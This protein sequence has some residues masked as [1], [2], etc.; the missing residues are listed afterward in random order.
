MKIWKLA[1]L[2]IGSLITLFLIV[3]A[4]NFFTIQSKQPV[5]D[6]EKINFDEEKAIK[7]LSEAITYKTISYQDRSKFELEEF[8]RFIDFLDR[9]YPSVHRELDLERVN[10]Y[11]LLYTWKG[12]D[13]SKKP[14]G[15]TSHYDVVPVLQGTEENWDHDPFSG[16]VSGDKIWGRG[17]L[18]DK[19]GVIG[20]LQALEHLIDEGFQPERDM[21]FMFGHDEEIGGEEGAM[22]IAALLKER[23]VQFDFVLDE[24]GAIV[25]NM[26]PGVK[27]P[28]GVVGISE[29]G[30]ATAKLSIEGSGGHSSQ[31]QSQTN[32][33]RIAGAI[34]KLEETQF[35]E[36]LKG[37]G[38]DL[39]EYAAPEMNFGMK[40]I[41]SNKFIFEPIIEEVLL[42]EPASAALIRTTIAPTIFQAGEQYNALPEEA[43]A[44]INLRLMPGDSLEDVKEFIEKTIEDDAI[45]VE[46]TGSEATKVSSLKGKPFNAIQQAARNVYS[47]AVIAPYLMVAGSDA[48]H[49]DSVADNTYR[50]LPVQITSE[51]LNRMHGTNEHV[52]TENYLNAVKFYVEFVK[53]SNRY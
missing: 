44:I 8:Q 17:T 22:A 1:S 48:K 7:N 9:T 23:G 26:V 35:P 10:D 25:E 28:V 50:F 14:I 42:N 33:G 34:A 5:P 24:G 11:A 13:S 4:F 3:T 19:I 2:I 27:A 6:P 18:D 36:D 43:S 52:S 21:Y 38:E 30:S 16:T 47:E 32:I 46:V 49:Y 39:F 20:I 45:A 29:K 53:E 37:P 31:P 51:D 41:F 40:Y 12:N 15:L